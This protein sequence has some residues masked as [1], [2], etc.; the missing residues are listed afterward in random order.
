MGTKLWPMLSR[1]PALFAPLLSAT[2]QWLKILPRRPPRARSRPTTEV[3][4]TMGAAAHPAGA[5]LS[6]V[7]AN[8]TSAFE[9]VADMRLAS[10]YS[11]KG[12]AA[13]DKAMTTRQRTWIRR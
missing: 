2:S 8:L 11:E 12:S 9:A 1:D 3:K 5:G 6:R 4:A 10:I 7:S 13:A